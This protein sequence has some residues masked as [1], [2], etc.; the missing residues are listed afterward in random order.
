MDPQEIVKSPNFDERAGGA[1][2]SLLVLHY[3]GMQS[4]GAALARL[5][6]PAA[7]VSAHYFIDEDGKTLQ[8]VADD[9]RAWHAG[10]SSWRGQSDV[11]SLSLGIELVNPGHEF[12]YRPFPNAQIAALEKLCASLMNEYNILPGNVLAHSDV[13]PGRKQDPGELFPWE[14][15]SAKGIG[16]WPAPAAMDF[17]AAKDIVAAPDVFQGLLGGLGY[18]P[19]AEFGALVAAFHRHYY[20]EKFAAGEDPSQPD[21]LSAA[22]LL[23]L[24]RQS[25][26]A[27]LEK[28]M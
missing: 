10:V 19:L 18:N 7:K 4:A 2:P 12:G 15:L 11:N 9:K 28:N 23:A 27:K 6:D 16:L 24:T 26:E 22:K 14:I 5:T 21:I 3:T 1:P 13:A 25:H 8:L 17:D 20:A